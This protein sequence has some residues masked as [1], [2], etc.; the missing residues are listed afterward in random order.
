MVDL[1]DESIRICPADESDRDVFALGT[2]II[3]SSHLHDTPE[4]D[5]SYADANE[6]VAI[7]I[8]KNILRDVTVPKIY[9]AGKVLL[10]PYGSMLHTYT[11]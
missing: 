3:K 2:V 5:Y 6:V 7:L 4:T 10:L 11:T 1:C 8:A 9:F